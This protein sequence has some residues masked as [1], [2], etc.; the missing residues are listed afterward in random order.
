VIVSNIVGGLGNQMFQYACGRAISVRTGQA[1]RLAT[2]QLDEYQS[3]NGLELLNI[4]DLDV[5][6]ATSE[7]MNALIGIRAN[8]K[9]RRMLGRPSMT[10][11]AW[12]AWC[13]EPHF[14]YWPAI[15]K[16][17]HPAYVHGYWQSEQ[18]F[19]EISNI[20]RKDFTFRTGWDPHDLAVRERMAA[21]VCASIHVRR[22]DYLSPKHKNVYD[23]CDVAYYVEA[24]KLLRQ[25]IPNINLFAF[26]DE[27]AWVESCL[28]P[29][30]GK[31][32]VISHNLGLKSSND[33]RLMSVA[34]HHIIANSSFS[35]WGAW[36]NPREDKTVIAP[37]SWFADGRSTSSLIPSSWTRL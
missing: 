9:V 36:L 13:N 29:F 34:D 14:A 6:I 20:I 19:E 12:G 11:A 7:E 35:W 18:Y 25:K 2:D 37:K 3:H 27:P 23:Q 10:W 30:I 32:E 5:S 24:V 31:V 28:Q 1:L 17:S 8:S 16:V 22:G 15:K 21:G 4:F 33:M 26:S